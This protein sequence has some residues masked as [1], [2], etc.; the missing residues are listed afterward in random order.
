MATT[1]RVWHQTSESR[2]RAQHREVQA[3]DQSV[4]E[5][6]CEIVKMSKANLQPSARCRTSTSDRPSSKVGRNANVRKQEE[7]IVTS[8]VLVIVGRGEITAGPHG[9][10]AVGLKLKTLCAF[11]QGRYLHT[12]APCVESKAGCDNGHYG[13]RNGSREL[14]FGDGAVEH[15]LDG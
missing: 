1:R 8:V 3:R 14:L 7:E 11:P 2:V 13:S 12:G 15:T 4:A 9:T 6:C 5:C 10:A